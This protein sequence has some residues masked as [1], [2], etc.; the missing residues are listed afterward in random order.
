M[1]KRTL[2]KRPELGDWSLWPGILPRAMVDKIDQIVDVY[3]QVGFNA[4]E[5]WDREAVLEF[6]VYRAYVDLADLQQRS[7]RERGRK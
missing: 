2:S 3:D 6:L 7:K 5:M 1:A 4:S